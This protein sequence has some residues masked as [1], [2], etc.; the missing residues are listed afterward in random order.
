MG[1]PLRAL[2]V[3][4]SEND[5]LLLVRQLKRGGFDVDFRRVDT[6]A[7]MNEA[8]LAQ[9]WDIIL[10]DHVMPKFSAPAA[11]EVLREKDFNI[12]FII[13]SGTIS[14][15]LAV[16]LMRAGAHD[17]ISKDD[18][19]RLVPAIERELRDAKTR[20]KRWEAV[21]ALRKSEEKFRS[22]VETTKEWIWTMDLN[23]KMSYNNPAIEDILG[24]TVEELQGQNTFDFMHEDDRKGVEEI[25]SKLI[26][27]KEG[28]NGLTIRWRHKDGTYRFLESN[29]VPVLDAEGRFVGYIGADRDVTE[30]KLAEIELRRLKEEAEAAALMAQIYL[31][32]IAH[33]L[34]NILSPVMMYSELIST[35]PRSHPWVKETATK[36]VKQID[37]A[38]SFVR[39]TRRLSESE[40]GE[41]KKVETVDL[42]T[43]L[44]AKEEEILER[45][46]NKRFNFERSLPSEGHI[47]AMGKSYIEDI[48]EEVLDNA[49]KHGK[50]DDVRVDI[51]VHP[52]ENLEGHG[53]WKVEIA[54][55]GPGIPDGT[56]K[57]LM[58]E[59]F[60][61][62][63]RMTRGIASSLSFMSLIA[64]H[65]GGRLRIEDRIQGDHTKGT[66]VVLLFRKV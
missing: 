10:C 38:V 33:D 1:K 49:A 11:L 9:T 15:E 21:E 56:K 5:A 12:P 26:P 29:A 7:A 16:A 20:I 35:D 65:I 4:D 18:L 50:S 31:D 32:F 30:K 55:Y 66:K 60:E 45:Y 37:R 42:L 19:S 52:I 3:E 40:R 53:Y 6:S 22:I 14:A 63:N 51:K 64:E 44:E 8:L 24:Y 57:E 28:W 13:V 47:N 34:T 36:V 23:G 54:D 25:V 2:I 48:I 39:N 17:W 43:V 62:S 59:V 61:P 58:V 27:Q 41:S 46:P